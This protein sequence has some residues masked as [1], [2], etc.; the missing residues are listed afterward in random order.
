MWSV[1]ST[2]MNLACTVGPLLLA[3]TLTN[4][5]WHA[6]FVLLGMYITGQFSLQILTCIHFQFPALCFCLHCIELI[7]LT[8]LTRVLGRGVRI[9]CAFYWCTS[10]ILQWFS[11]SEFGTWYSIMNTTMNLAC[12]VGPVLTAYLTLTTSWRA[13]MAASGKQNHL[14]WTL[15]WGRD[16]NFKQGWK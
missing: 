1:L 3:A 16:L 13:G 7:L 15:F 2:S 12:S 8:W 6:F 14:Q 10:I 5:R 9:K 11:P 4:L